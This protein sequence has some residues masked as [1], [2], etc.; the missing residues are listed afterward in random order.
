M[1]EN[2]RWPLRPKNQRADWNLCSPT[3]FCQCIRERKIWK[4][5][6][7]E[8]TQ[9]WG[10]GGSWGGGGGH[11]F[12]HCS[13]QTCVSWKHHYMSILA[14]DML[15]TYPHITVKRLHV[16]PSHHKDE[17]CVES[18]GSGVVGHHFSF[19]PAQAARVISHAMVYPTHT[20]IVGWPERSKSIR[21]GRTAEARQG[22][23][24]ERHRPA[25]RDRAGTA[26]LKRW[27]KF[28]SLRFFFCI[29][30]QMQEWRLPRKQP[31]HKRIRVLADLEFLF[32]SFLKLYCFGCFTQ[33]KHTSLIKKILWRN[34]GQ[35]TFQKWK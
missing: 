12:L 10:K 9:L 20:C 21:S 2:S 25:K 19:G 28:G 8:Q 23:R 16:Q 7:K 35:P 32:E 11:E 24:V 13:S 34:N 4:T 33:Q 29:L 5:G 15:C 14:K 22:S 3:L 26:D 27:E 1:C 17:R 31:R 18:R 30:P 6:K